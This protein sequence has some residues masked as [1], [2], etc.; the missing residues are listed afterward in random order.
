MK[1]FT[2]P[3]I[4]T[5]TGWIEISASSLEEAKKI[6]QEMN[7]GDGIPPY[8]LKDSEAESECLIEEIEEGPA[9]ENDIRV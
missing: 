7:D 3:V 6:A 4:V 8:S 5:E 9:E 2:V 1:N